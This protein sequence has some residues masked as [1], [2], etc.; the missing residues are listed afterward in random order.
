MWFVP[1]PCHTLVDQ[2]AGALFDKLGFIEGAGYRCGAE[3]RIHGN[4]LY[5]N[6]LI[7]QWSVFAAYTKNEH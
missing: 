2:R 3:A 1:K 6:A 7:I 4:I 5:C